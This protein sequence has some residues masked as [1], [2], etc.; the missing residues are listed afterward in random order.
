MPRPRSNTSNPKLVQ[1]KRVW[2][3]EWWNSAKRYPERVSCRT[4]HR[5]EAEDYLASFKAGLLN[6]RPE[7]PVRLRA[8][9]GRYL[10]ARLAAE[11]SPTLRTAVSHLERLLGALTVPE[12]SSPV[13]EVYYDTRRQEGRRV[14]GGRRVPLQDGTLAKE[15]VTLRAAIR[16]AI[17]EKLIPAADEPHIRVPSGGP[18]RERWLTRE[19]FDRLLAAAQAFHIKLFIVLALATA[20]R[21]GAILGLTWNQIDETTGMVNLGQGRRNKRRATVP[22]TQD[23]LAV[24]RAAHARATTPYV[25]EWRECSVKSI[26]TGFYTAVRRAGLSEDVTPNVLRHTAATWMAMDGVSLDDIGRFLGDSVKVV[27]KVYAKFTPDYLRR[28]SRALARKTR[29]VNAKR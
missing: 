3:V 2:Y 6:P 4:K 25:I 12:L 10:S 1:R 14:K 9:L 27:E 17:R 22:L 21:R 5:G 11:C 18:P 29:A 23:A 8:I 20:G 24:L 15:G 16:W 19:E 28:A 13:I 7:A 26:R